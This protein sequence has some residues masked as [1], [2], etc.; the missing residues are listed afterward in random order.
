MDKKS[1]KAAIRARNRKNQIIQRHIDGH[2]DARDAALEAQQA[3][4]EAQQQVQTI[5]DDPDN[6]VTRTQRIRNRLTGKKRKSAD[7]WNRFAGTAAAGGM[8]R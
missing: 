1:K 3:A 7:I 8:G 4:L 6:I 2:Q 5:S